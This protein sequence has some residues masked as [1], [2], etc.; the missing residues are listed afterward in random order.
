M[1]RIIGLKRPI[2]EVKKPIWIW[3]KLIETW[4][5]FKLLNSRY[6]IYFLILIV[7][8]IAVYALSLKVDYKVKVNMIV[9]PRVVE[10]LPTH[11]KDSTVAIR[12]KSGYG[13]G[14]VISKHFVLSAAHLV[15]SPRGRFEEPEEEEK[16]HENFV[17]VQVRHHEL[18]VNVWTTATVARIDDK[19]D[20]LLLFVPI[21]LP[22]AISKIATVDTM[23]V[24]DRLYIVG[25]P[26]GTSA[27]NC[28]NGTL[29]AKWND[30]N[31]D[32]PFLWHCSAPVFPGNSGGPVYLARTGE[33]VGIVVRVPG[34]AF[35]GISNNVSYFVPINHI[36]SFVGPQ[37]K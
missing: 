35:Y 32:A 12:T 15:H 21:E 11:I 7:G 5:K 14:V 4:G 17:E 30:W 18:R 13:S 33:L 27:P 37:Q 36:N 34:S 1:R 26:C 16:E 6:L 19:S 3:T 9:R 22:H 8:I 29:T 28:S 25:F 24:N 31:E 20:L 2:I 23:D 10:E